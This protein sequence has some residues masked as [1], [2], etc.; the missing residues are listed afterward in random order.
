[1]SQST[2]REHN[3]FSVEKQILNQYLQTSPYSLYSSIT[4]ILLMMGIW[5]NNIIIK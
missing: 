5:A 1:M 3:S 2:S 4:T